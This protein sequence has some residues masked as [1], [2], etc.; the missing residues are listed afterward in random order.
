MSVAEGGII[1]QLGAGTLW[2]WRAGSVGFRAGRRAAEGVY[3]MA[4]AVERA[5]FFLSRRFEGCLGRR[6]RRNKA[7][8]PRA[9]RCRWPLLRVAANGAW[10]HG[11]RLTANEDPHGHYQTVER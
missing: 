7:R 1:A 6:R 9:R 11:V 10:A 5:W 3:V 4:S 2:F 8:L